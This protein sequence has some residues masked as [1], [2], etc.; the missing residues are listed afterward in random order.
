MVNT[1]SVQRGC[2]TCEQI[3]REIDGE[4]PSC[5]G[6]VCFIKSLHDSV[7]IDDRGGGTGNIISNTV[8]EQYMIWGVYVMEDILRSIDHRATYTQIG[9]GRILHSRIEMVWPGQLDFD[10]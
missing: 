6:K 10:S 4:I 8:C 1:K 9:K 3:K 5:L 2:C 7:V